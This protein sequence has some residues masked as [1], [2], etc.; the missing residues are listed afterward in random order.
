MVRPL[1]V[2]EAH[3]CAFTQVRG[4]V[5]GVATRARTDWK[6]RTIRASNWVT[7]PA[8]VNSWAT[9]PMP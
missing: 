9:F 7:C 1:A 6:P 5:E 3:G 4:M 2:V 8:R